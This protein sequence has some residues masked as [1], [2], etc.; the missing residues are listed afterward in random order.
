MS[1]F[2]EDHL[3]NGLV[4]HNTLFLFCSNQEEVEIYKEKINDQ[5]GRQLDCTKDS[6]HTHL[7]IGTIKENLLELLIKLREVDEL[8]ERPIM[9]KV[10]KDY[11]ETL[12][13]DDLPSSQMLKMLQEALRLGLMASGQMTRELEQSMVELEEDQ[14]EIRIPLQ[15][16]TSGAEGNINTEFSKRAVFPPCYVN[17]L[18]NRGTGAITASS[19][20]QP[21]P[22]AGKLLL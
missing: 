12:S 22:I 2:N 9:I 6:Q 15:S 17:L 3:L 21:T 14:L 19:P 4:L 5:L 1:H 8:T 13:M 11:T 18:A 10:F 16:P 20:G 7:V